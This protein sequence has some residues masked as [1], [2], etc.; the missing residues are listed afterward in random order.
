MNL[1]QNTSQITCDTQCICNSAIL[2]DLCLVC[3]QKC[4]SNLCCQFPLLHFPVARIP[5]RSCP[6]FCRSNIFSVSHLWHAL[7]NSKLNFTAEH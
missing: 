6:S 1:P 4:P 3:F 7:Q 5:V 2:G